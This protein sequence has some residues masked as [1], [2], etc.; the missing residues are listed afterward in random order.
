[1]LLHFKANVNDKYN[2]NVIYRKGEVHE[3]DDKRAKELLKT[4]PSLVEEVVKPN[5]A[6]DTKSRTPR[7]DKSTDEANKETTPDAKPE[8]GG[9]TEQNETST[10]QEPDSDTD[11]ANKE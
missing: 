7:N 3:L 2:T 10:S 8:E 5:E 4:L 9:T 11:E 6:K 1:M